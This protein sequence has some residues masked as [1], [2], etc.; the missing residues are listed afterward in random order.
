LIIAPADSVGV[1][2]DSILLAKNKCGEQDTAE[3][4]GT[5]V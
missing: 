3:L 2:V 1:V 4:F 5:A